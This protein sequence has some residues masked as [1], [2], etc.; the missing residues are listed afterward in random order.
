MGT[1]QA[2]AIAA[3]VDL[4]SVDIKPPKGEFGESVILKGTIDG[5]SQVTSFFVGGKQLPAIAKGLSAGDTIKLQY[6]P[7][8]YNPVVKW[9]GDTTEE[10]PAFNPKQYTGGNKRGAASTDSN[11][12]A[13]LGDVQFKDLPA[14]MA[15]AWAKDLVM[16]TEMSVDEAAHALYN[17]TEKLNELASNGE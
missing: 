8:K 10:P 7:G 5:D 3:V 9:I 2:T 1:G 17:L 14:T 4:S 13:T 6:V 15:I 16:N 12:N 11:C